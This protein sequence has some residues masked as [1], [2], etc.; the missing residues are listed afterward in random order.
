MRDNQKPTGA[1]SAPQPDQ[2]TLL[3]LFAIAALPSILILRPDAKLS[4]IAAMSYEM[5]LAMKEERANHT[6]V[7]HG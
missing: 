5:A 7:Q 4:R 3:D 2:A 6:E 1:P